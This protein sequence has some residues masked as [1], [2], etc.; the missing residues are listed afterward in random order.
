MPLHAYS[1]RFHP[2]KSKAYVGCGDMF[3]GGIGP[4][5]VIDTENRQIEKLIFPD[6][7]H[8]AQFIDLG[9]K[10]DSGK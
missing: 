4:I 6:L 1:V 5:V 2:E 8:T 10:L 7:H 3:K 9:P